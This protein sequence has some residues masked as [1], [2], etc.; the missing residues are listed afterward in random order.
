[1]I[2]AASAFFDAAARYR[3]A[4]DRLDAGDRIDD[5]AASAA[6]AAGI[7]ERDAVRAVA[8]A[9]IA[10][11]EDAAGAAKVLAHLCVEEVWPDEARALARSLVVAVERLAAEW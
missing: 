4:I 1:M 5:A 8:A 11:A 6:S 3:T 7:A 10:T 2:E 9:P